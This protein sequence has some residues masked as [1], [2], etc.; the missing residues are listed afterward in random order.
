[1]RLVVRGLIMLVVFVTGLACASGGR[2]EP[3]PMAPTTRLRV[4]NRSFLDHNIYV[5]RGGERIR[6]GTATGSMTTY[7]KLP[8]NLVFGGTPLRFMADPIGA[9]G[10]PVSDEITVHPGDDVALIIPPR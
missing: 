8:S 1:M 2:R 3:A 5:M 4:D 6:L 7:F 10:Q 9:R